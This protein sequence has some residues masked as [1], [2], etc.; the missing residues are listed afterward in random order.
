VRL[1]DPA[2]N[3]VGVLAPAPVAPPATVIV[4]TIT[5]ERASRLLRSLADAGGSHETLVVDNGT[6]SAELERSVSAIEGG[7]LLR[8]PSNAGYSRA[9]NLAARSA[10]GEVLVLLNDDSVVDEGYIERITEPLDPTAGVV[11]AT[12]VM[13]DAGD[14]ELIE[15]AGVELDRTLLPFDYLNGEPLS[16]LDEPVPDPIGPSGA[17]A[18]FWRDA[19]LEIGGFDEE[20]FAYFE[21]VDLVLRMRLAGGTCRLAPSAL[22]THEHSATLG[23]G[24][25]RKDFLIGYGRGYLLRKWG[26][27][28][29]RRIPGVV[30]RE[31]ALSAGQVLMDRNLGAAS[32]RIRGL[33]SAPERHQFPAEALSDPASV[34]ETMSRRWRRR[35]R[36]R[37]RS[38]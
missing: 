32:G 14:P 37:R 8:L 24:S 16:V 28:T 34:I 11:M 19:F 5:P 4:P 17:A 38:A 23:P 33:R 9:V 7:E 36:L 25:R 6:G 15:T 13:R 22:G 26:V 10:Q 35:A 20:L 1:S 21:D 3:G 29:P 30:L 2:S 27:L 18:A 12:G 31:L